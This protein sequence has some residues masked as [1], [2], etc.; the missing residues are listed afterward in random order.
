MSTSDRIPAAEG[1]LKTEVTDNNNTKV[2]LT[3]KH[4][5]P[6]EKIASGATTYVVWTQPSVAGREPSSN[7][8]IQNLGALEIDQQLDGKLSAVTPLHNFQ[9]FVTAEPSAVVTTPSGEHLLWTQVSE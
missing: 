8:Q 6:P 9:L 2:D 5:A 7:E 4:L 3:V 1:D